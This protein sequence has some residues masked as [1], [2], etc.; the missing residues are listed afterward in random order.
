[1][2]HGIPDRFPRQLVCQETRHPRIVTTQLGRIRLVV[3]CT[4]HETQA[5]SKAEG[6][7]NRAAPAALFY[8][9]YFVGHVRF[10]I[11]ATLYDFRQAHPGI[12]NSPIVGCPV[13]TI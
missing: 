11:T 9:P 8:V 13:K 2:V 3:V 5:P 1:M 4:C 12:R 7:L 10:E 6:V